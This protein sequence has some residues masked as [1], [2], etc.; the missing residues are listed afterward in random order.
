MKEFIEEKEDVQVEKYL[1][2]FIK[3]Y[4]HTDGFKTVNFSVLFIPG[5]RRALEHL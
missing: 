1:G 2:M 3:L 4:I 5:T